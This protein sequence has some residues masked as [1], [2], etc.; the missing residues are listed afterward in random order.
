V[1]VTGASSSEST[2][3]TETNELLQ[4]TN[5]STSSTLKYETSSQSSPLLVR[6]V[7]R[8]EDRTKLIR[9]SMS[10]PHDSDNSNLVAKYG[11]I[12]NKNYLIFK[13]K[14][15]Q[16]FFIKLDSQTGQAAGGDSRGE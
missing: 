5:K 8:I 16:L 15:N 10:C 9:K 1:A 12:L 2:S 14:S 11:F 7:A 6:K 4:F 3:V 13:I